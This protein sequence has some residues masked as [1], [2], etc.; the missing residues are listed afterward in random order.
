[1]LAAE[2]APDG[3]RR[4]D[5]SAPEPLWSQVLADLRRRIA[6]GSFSESFPTD[7]SLVR[8]YGVS[9]QTVREALR[10]LVAEGVV[11]RRRRTGSRLRPAE[12]EQ[13]LGALYSFFRTIEDQGISQTSRVR[14]LEVRRAPT[15]ARK[16][17]L[18]D[19][20]DLVYLERLR[21][22]G[23]TPLALD[24]VWLPHGTAAALLDADF[25][26]TALYDEL[27]RRCGTAPALAREQIRPIVPGSVQARL[28]GLSAPEPCF[29]IERTSWTDQGAALEWRV[30]VVRGDRYAFVAEWAPR[31]PIRALQQN[32][33]SGVAGHAA[34]PASTSSPNRTAPISSSLRPA[35][36]RP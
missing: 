15:A 23:G 4:P 13:P 26:H 3:V 22:A 34:N 25:T 14:A 12:F 30:S 7:A 19:G 10:R 5:R 35:L 8:D 28:L 36:R 24:R 6:L 27:A 33:S 17:G 11:E 9:R 16:L 31:M 32:D 2:V 21:L 18:D 20:A 1:M 29:A